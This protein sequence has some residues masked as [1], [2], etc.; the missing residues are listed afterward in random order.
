MI[1]FEYRHDVNSSSVTFLSSSNSEKE[2]SEPAVSTTLQ[3]EL[4]TQYVDKKEQLNDDSEIEV[5]AVDDNLTK[6]KM[7]SET[8][9]GLESANCFRAW[10]QSAPPA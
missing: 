3:P 5:I 6:T 9:K 8:P 10:D 2:A 7:N 1:I 4:D